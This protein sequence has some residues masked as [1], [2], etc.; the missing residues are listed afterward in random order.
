M[1]ELD[2]ETTKQVKTTKG[3]LKSNPDT[4]NN[5]TDIVKPDLTGFSTTNTFYATISSNNQ[6]VKGNPISEEPPEDWYD[7]ENQKWANIMTLNTTTSGEGAEHNGDMAVWVWIPR[8]EFKVDTDLK[9]VDTVFI[10]PTQ[11]KADDGY[12]IPDAFT[13][14]VDGKA[15]QLSGIWV[16]KYEVS[17]PQMPIG[18]TT[19]GLS[20]G[21]GFE[22]T[23]VIYSDGTTV[24]STTEASAQD[25]KKGTIVI[26]NKATGATSTKQ[27]TVGT[28]T[29]KITGL[30]VGMYSLE[31][32]INRAYKNVGDTVHPITFTQEIYVAEKPK[33]NA[34]ELT[35][36]KES[37]TNAYVYFVMYD[38]VKSDG[39]V[40]QRLVFNGDTPG[41]MNG[42]TFVAGTPSGW[43]DYETQ[44][45]ANIII[46]DTALATGTVCK[47]YN[48]GSGL[49]TNAKITMWVWIPRYQFK[50]DK[51]SQVTWVSGTSGAS[52]A[53][54]A[55][56]DGFSFKKNASETV[57]LTGLW[58]G[59]YEIGR[60]DNATST[61]S[62]EQI[63]TSKRNPLLTGN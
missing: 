19:K 28:N 48:S 55:V 12:Q 56:P 54:Y 50:V 23:D 43:Y 1:K 5:E 13:F 4:D 46:S 63:T 59:K 60:D 26:T 33:A 3:G 42:S 38:N 52:D 21:T 7:Y 9:T 41:Y 40:G 14:T 61:P 6:I 22:I 53:S 10:P 17:N 35:Y 25:E 45:W 11:T 34:P 16:A 36:F 32:T 51:N 37:A 39:K 24:R 15:T 58:V 57:Q 20:D 27:F 44:K 18:I 30:T 49:P 8:Y 2:L 29:A 47:L 31:V 62:G